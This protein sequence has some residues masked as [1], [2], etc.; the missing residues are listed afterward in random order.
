[1]KKYLFAI[2]A[3][4]GVMFTGCD[5]SKSSKEPINVAISPDYPPFTFLEQDKKNPKKENA[6]GFEIDLFNEI[7]ERTGRKVNYKHMPFGEIF[8]S[9]EKKEADAAIANITVTKER[10]EKMSFSKPYLSTGYALVV[11]DKAIKS[12]DDLK[13]KKL[14]IQKDTSYEKLFNK[15]LKKKYESITLESAKHKSDLVQKLKDDYAQALFLG[16]AEAEAIA[17]ELGD[18]FHMIAL[19]FDESNNF[20]IAYPKD[21]PLKAELDA[22]LSEMLK[23]DTVKKLKKKWSV[24]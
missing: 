15:K 2:L 24:K 13:D 8:G 22:V 10:Q 6:V 14:T 17:S 9:L 4:A 5:N 21:S 23:D 12:L 19:N 7:G 11:K 18:G 16:K 20:A 3:A 1:M